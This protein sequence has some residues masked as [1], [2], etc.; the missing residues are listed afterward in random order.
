MSPRFG[1]LLG[2]TKLSITG[3][4]LPEAPHNVTCRIDG[5]TV[6]GVVPQDTLINCI[7]PLGIRLA[8]V[9]VEVSTDGGLTYPYNSTYAYGNDALKMHHLMI[10]GLSISRI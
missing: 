6:R 2:G 5:V 3:A 1:P 10:D 9:L 7:T 8:K 4:C